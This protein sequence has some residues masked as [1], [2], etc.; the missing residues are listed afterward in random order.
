MSRSTRDRWHDA[1][2]DSDD[3]GVWVGANPLVVCDVATHAFGRD[4]RT[5]EEYVAQWIDHIDW[6]EVSRR[7]KRVDRM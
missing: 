6:N 5:R 2:M 3:G 4:Y 7:Y 1:V